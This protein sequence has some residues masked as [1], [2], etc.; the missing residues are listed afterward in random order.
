MSLLKGLWIKMSS[1]KNVYELQ[2][3]H[4]WRFVFVIRD[5]HLWDWGAVT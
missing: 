2:T 3:W 5:M 4:I 1:V